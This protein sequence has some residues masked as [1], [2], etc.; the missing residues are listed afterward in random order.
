MIA[1]GWLVDAGESLEL[2]RFDSHNGQSSKRRALDSDRKK[3][4]RKASA[5]E[6]DKKRTREEK[7]REELKDIPHTPQAGQPRAAIALQTYLD[8]CKQAGK[9]P[10]P[11]DDS[12]FEYASKVGIPNDFLR[13]QWL[14]FKARYTEAGAKRYKAW[15][16]VFGK[17]VR[18]NW[19]HLWYAKDGG[20]V[21][22]TTGEQARKAH[23][24]GV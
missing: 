8:D 9:K 17:S 15:P 19:F 1:V 14:E 10:I 23:G 4:V 12:V 22:S 5:S 13:L 24:E 6:A 20:Y 7:R 11:E 16:T 2:P 21:L 3:E 18:G